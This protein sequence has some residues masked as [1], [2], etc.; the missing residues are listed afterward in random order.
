M[1]SDAGGSILTHAFGAIFGL[2]ITLGL[3][4]KAK[5]IPEE[6]RKTTYTSDSFAMIG[7][8]VLWMVPG[9]ISGSN[10]VNFRYRGKF[11]LPRTKINQEPIESGNTSP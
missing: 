7:T 6:N 9:I 2:G 8:I 11:I 10:T 1:T 5:N 3:G 4:T